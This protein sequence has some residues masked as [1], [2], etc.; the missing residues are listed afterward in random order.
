MSSPTPWADAK[1]RILAAGLGV[2][3]AWPNEPIT[4]PE[5][6]AIWLRVSSV[7]HMLQPIEIGGKS[8][9]EE[10]TLLCDIVIPRGT[11]IDAAQT[12]AK[13]ILNTFRGLPPGPTVYLTGAIGSSAEEEIRG[14]W[15]VMPVAVD[16]RYQD[17]M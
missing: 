11:G 7:S 12:L 8:W 6:P 14:M 9:Q 1:A 4:L 17:T 10:G 3:I 16:W 2:T 13:T 5:P 15:L